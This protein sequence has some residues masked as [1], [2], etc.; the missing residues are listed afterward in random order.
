[1]AHTPR[2]IFWSLIGIIVSGAVGGVAGWAVISLLGW[3]G[4]FGALVAAAIGMVAATAVFAMITIVLRAL[5][6]VR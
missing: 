2:S 3:S 1:M 6:I 5:G 4:V